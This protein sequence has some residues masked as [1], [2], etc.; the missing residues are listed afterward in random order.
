MFKN[1]RDWLLVVVPVAL[2]ISVVYNN[3]ATEVKKADAKM[4]FS[5]FNQKVKSKEISSVVIKNGTVV[6]G[7]L[8]GVKTPDGKIGEEKPFKANVIVYDKLLENLEKNNIPTEVAMENGATSGG[9]SVMKLIDV[10]GSLLW[11]VV[12]VLLFKSMKGD[13]FGMGKSNI[14]MFTSDMQKVRFSDVLGIDEAKQ[15]VSEIVDFLRDPKKYSRL[16]AKIPK[17]VLL[18]GPP[19]TGKTLLAKAIAGEAGVPFF[20]TSGS[21]FVEM[22][23]GVGAS[24]VRALF[25]QATKSAPCLI[26]IDEIDAVGRHRGSGYGG[27]NDER[28][29]TLNQLLV[30]MDGFASNKGVIVIAATNR[31]DVLDEALLRPGRFDRQVYIDL[32]DLKGREAILAKYMKEVNILSDVEPLSVARGTPGFSGADLANLV[33]EAALIAARKNRKQ[34]SEDD[35]EF[36]RDK[37][38][39]GAE[40]KSKTMSPDEIKNTA[41]HEAGHALCAVLLPE[42]DPIHKATIIPRGR[43]LGLVQKLPERDKVSVNITEIKSDIAVAMAGRVCEELF[44]GRDKVT[45]GAS[46]DIQN[47]TNY[48]RRAVIEWGL[49]DKI[50]PV[51]YGQDDN[52]KISETTSREIDEEVKR[53]LDE[54]Y[55][56]AKATV[57][58]NKAKV[59]KI[60]KALLEYETL[61][62]DEVRAIV[63]GGKVAF[64]KKEE[65][66][67]APLIRTS[68]LPSTEK[69]IKKEE[70]KKD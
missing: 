34:I 46:S 67:K 6:E 33:N 53:M 68:S 16:G 18:V 38:L 56:L 60:A 40:K 45:T 36:A 58:K 48:A 59:E 25:E 22:F 4:T 44:F 30:E 28:E 39:M 66:T 27:G 62:G 61:T 3:S 7:K 64:K 31:V 49:S 43:S 42:V 70:E 24:R 35:F 47:A 8:K 1:W 10:F 29:Q 52:Y 55:K 2:V 13:K 32:P 12:L 65:K 51:F 5:E 63:K 15:D 54:G 9:F 57:V 41:Y 21:E 11:I 14:K 20:S 23:V 19:G 37:I 17:G 50:G 26:F 69:K